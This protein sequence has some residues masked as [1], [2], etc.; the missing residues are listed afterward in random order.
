MY[1]FESKIRYSE[2]DETGC[3]A[4]PK[5]VDYFQ[6]CSNMQSDFLGV[7]REY[8]EEKH[9]A[10]VLSFWQIVIDRRP[11]QNES[12]KI[13][14]FPYDF[15]GVMGLRNFLIEDNAGN[16]IVR[17]NSIWTLLDMNSGRPVRAGA[18]ITQHYPVEEKLPMDY[19]S[20]KVS[21]PELGETLTPITVK[22]EYIDTNHHM[23]NAKYLTVAMNYVPCH[24]EVKEIRIEYKKQAFLGD[25]IYPFVA[26]IEGGLA[27][28]LRDA[29][30]NPYVNMHILT[31]PGGEVL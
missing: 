31:I 16:R 17:A 13:G 21:I 10:W 3:L 22:R 1:K 19:A 28:S 8:L 25:E 15:N 29:D 30:G 12:V 5:I 6:D 23:N 24:L 9:L 2:L 11:G 7:G 20:R 27:I 26:S 14:T 4:V 18:E